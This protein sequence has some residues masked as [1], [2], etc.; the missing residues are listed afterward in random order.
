MQHGIQIVALTT[1]VVA[2]IIMALAMPAS[3]AVGSAAASD[4]AR[5]VQVK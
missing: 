4:P 5:L 2:G 1:A 3:A